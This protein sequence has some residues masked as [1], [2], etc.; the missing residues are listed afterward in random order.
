[1]RS[2][3]TDATGVPSEDVVVAATISTF[4]WF[5]RIL[6]SSPPVYPVPPAMATRIF[7]CVLSI[8]YPEDYSSM[9]PFTE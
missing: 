8:Q 5:S 9:F 4:G 6:N 3:W 7:L 1:M 2:L